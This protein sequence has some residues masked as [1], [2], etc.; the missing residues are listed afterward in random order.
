VYLFAILA[1]A[2]LFSAIMS[3]SVHS[4]VVTLAIFCNGNSQIGPIFYR[5][6]CRVSNG[7]TTAFRYRSPRMTSIYGRTFD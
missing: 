6:G 1:I 2:Y 7:N 4:L 5:T 3:S